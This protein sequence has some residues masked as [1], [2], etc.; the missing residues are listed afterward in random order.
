MPLEIRE[1]IIKVDIQESRQRENGD[2]AERL[3]VLKN[4]VVKECMKKM[5]RN[6]EKKL[7]R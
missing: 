6:W 2:V 3:E 7:T 1:L 4:E 5:I